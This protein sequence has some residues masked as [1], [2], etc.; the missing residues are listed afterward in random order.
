M[1]HSINHSKEAAGLFKQLL[2]LNQQRRGVALE[3]EDTN[4][5]IRRGH[6]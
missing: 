5:R 6:V 3:Q 2:Q 4:P 1:P